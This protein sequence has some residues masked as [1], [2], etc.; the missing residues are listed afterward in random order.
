MLDWF[1][2]ALQRTPQQDSKKCSFGKYP[3]FGKTARRDNDCTIDCQNYEDCER[4]NMKGK[5]FE[6]T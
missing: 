6:D 2:E 5:P 4:V 1:R 3:R